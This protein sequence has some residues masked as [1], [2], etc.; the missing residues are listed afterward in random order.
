MSRRKSSVKNGRV[1]ASFLRS[2]GT[3][4]VDEALRILEVPSSATPAEIKA[5]YRRMVK[6][7]HP[8]RHAL[9][10]ARRA[11]A[12]EALK[13]VVLAYQCLRHGVPAAPPPEPK[14]AA[15]APPGS[16]FSVRQT[17]ATDRRR[18][19][20]RTR[21]H[22]ADWRWHVAVWL[23]AIAA[24]GV[25]SLLVSLDRA[26]NSEAVTAASPPTFSAASVAPTFSADRVVPARA[27]RIGLTWHIEN[28]TGRRWTQCTAWVGAKWSSFAVLDPGE[29]VTVLADAFSPG[30]G[31]ADDGKALQLEC[32]WR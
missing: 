2:G 6:V 29:P 3:V 9:D 18:S 15:A 16:S 28:P 4:R 5:A 30:L 23:P 32:F 8:D 22:A 17:A 7:C 12:D 31:P 24:L 21:S 26:P 13:R 19:G 20:P 25:L 14:T 11:R 27:N 10:E 1:G